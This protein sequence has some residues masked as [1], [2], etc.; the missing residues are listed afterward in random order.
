[1][2]QVDSTGLEKSERMALRM[3]GSLAKAV[4]DVCLGFVFVDAKLHYSEEHACSEQVLR[5]QI[6]R[7][8]TSIQAVSAT[9]TSSSSIP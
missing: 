3:H 6:C 9:R 1:M 4:I 8:S 2:K 7:V 5:N